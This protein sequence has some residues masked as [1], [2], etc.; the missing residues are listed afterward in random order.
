MMMMTVIILI[1]KKNKRLTTETNITKTKECDG[2]IDTKPPGKSL[3]VI[4]DD[5]DISIEVMDVVA[6]NDNVSL[7][8]QPL[9][10]MIAVLMLILLPVLITVMM[11]SPML[12]LMLMMMLILAM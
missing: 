10:L 3:P 11:T 12:M 6:G 8:I 4:D 9:R 1:T 5:D 2:I 7:H